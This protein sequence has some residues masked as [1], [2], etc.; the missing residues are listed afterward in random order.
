[1]DEKSF[2]DKVMTNNI[3]DI[4]AGSYKFKTGY[5]NRGKYISDRLKESYSSINWC[6][7]IYEEWKGHGEFS[8]CNTSY[9]YYCRI[10]NVYTVILGWKK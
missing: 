8:A 9:Y 10:D 7:F 4:I 3:K 2:M 6:V 5:T 1:M